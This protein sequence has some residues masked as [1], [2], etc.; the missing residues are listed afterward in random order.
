MERCKASNNNRA[1]TV[2]QLF[3]DVIQEVGL[4]RCVRGGSLLHV[5]PSTKW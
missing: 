1:N 5:E 3:T 2:L 4:P